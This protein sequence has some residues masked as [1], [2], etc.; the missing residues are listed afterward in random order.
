VFRPMRN[1]QSVKPQGR[2]NTFSCIARLKTIPMFAKR[3]S[4]VNIQ[5]C[6]TQNMMVNI[7]NFMYCTCRRPWPTLTILKNE[8]GLLLFHEPHLCWKHN[9]EHRDVNFSAQSIWH[10]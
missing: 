8:P 5:S 10:T 1:A 2:M 4:M 7:E 9:F 3:R 6:A